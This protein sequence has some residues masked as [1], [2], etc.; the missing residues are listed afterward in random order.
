MTLRYIAYSTAS[1]NALAA[2]DTGDK[3]LALGRKASGGADEFLVILCV[4]EPD[5]KPSRDVDYY[6]LEN[7]ETAVVMWRGKNECAQRFMHGSEPAE[8]RDVGGVGTR[9][10]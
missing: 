4:G 10:R 6:R 3:A 5:G 1:M 2:G 7:L 9:G 8:E